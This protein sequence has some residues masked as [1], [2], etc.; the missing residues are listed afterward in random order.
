MLKGFTRLMLL[1][2]MAAFGIGPTASVSTPAASAVG[3]SGLL[4]G[5]QVPVEVPPKPPAAETA[6]VAPPAESVDPAFVAGSNGF[7]IR[8]LHELRASEG[9]K[10]WF[11][12]P[13]SASL[14][15]SM[16]ANGARGQTQAQILKA[17][18]LDGVAIGAVNAAN[19][20][21]QSILA[22][23]DPQV[24]LQVANSLWVKEGH[25]LAPGFEDLM[26]SQYQAEVRGVP[27]GDPRATTAMN[28]WVKAATKGKIPSMV[29]QTSADDRLYL[30]NAIY[31]KGAW[32][33]KFDAS[34]TKPEAFTR[35][36]GSQ[37]QVPM[38]HQSGRYRHLK[39]DQFQAAALPF[40][41]GEI[42]LYL[43]RPNDGVPLSDFLAKLTPETLEAWM[44]QFRQAPGKI[45]LPRFELAVT[46]DLKEPLQGLGMQLPFGDQADLSGLLAS[47]TDGLSVSSVAQKSFLS[48][49]E[50]GAEAAA[51]TGIGVTVTSLQP[52]QEPF[53][54]RLDRPFF[55]A[56]RDDRTGTL[57]FLGTIIDPG[58]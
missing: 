39:G 35:L 21:L 49:T 41:D 50:E 51:V 13:T 26:R 4:P 31:F 11:L 18:G 28:D 15:L 47:P 57:L 54:L 30:M 23:P 44:R 7:G 53:D 14:A 10:N 22:N 37:V 12:S 45:A 43:F 6:P 40:G 9:E 56:I 1:A 33:T 19:R 16:L 58:E 20:N 48:I 32:R 38:M 8:L 52:S 3:P 27:F 29:D 36:D 5:A 46:M 34:Q 24:E 42:S 25:R 55:L 17:V 2:L